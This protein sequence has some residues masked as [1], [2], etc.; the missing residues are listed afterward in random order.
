MVDPWVGKIPWRR[1]RQPTPVFLP[2][3]SHGQTSLVAYHP[4]G[5]KASDVTD[6]VRR[7]H[8]FCP[9]AEICSVWMPPYIIT[10]CPRPHT[11]SWEWGT[12]KMR[13]SCFRETSGFLLLVMRRPRHCHGYHDVFSYLL[14]FFSDP[15]KCLFGF[16]R[17]CFKNKKFS[18]EKWLYRLK[19]F[20]CLCFL[21]C[22]RLFPAVL[23]LNSSGFLALPHPALPFQE[24]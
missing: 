21:M 22:S 8:P 16:L 20:F 13:C 15:E 9:R 3:E 12:D 18:F 2:G 11:N 5:H 6:H 24:K 7:Y 14:T 1:E 4:E 19:R 10:Q 23:K 17:N